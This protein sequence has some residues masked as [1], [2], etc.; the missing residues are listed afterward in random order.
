M[1]SNILLRVLLVSSLCIDIYSAVVPHLMRRLHDAIN[2]A[3]I[4]I[5]K[6]TIA[7]GV[8]PNCIYLQRTALRAACI[9]KHPDIIEYLISV[10]AQITD[11]AMRGF[12]ASGN[13]Y[14]T[15]NDIL[16][17]LRVLTKHGGKWLPNKV[18]MGYLLPV[19][20]AQE[21]NQ[22]I[23]DLHKQIVDILREAKQKLA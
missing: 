3:D 7:C 10:G 19:M 17:S 16:N 21:N 20:L 5:V 18:P 22:E 11:D 4:E 23:D 2:A 9:R 13:Q 1:Q 6:D 15:K 14:Y 12:F 8:D